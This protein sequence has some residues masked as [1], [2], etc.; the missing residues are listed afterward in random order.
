MKMW[1]AIACPRRPD[2]AFGEVNPMHYF[3][4]CWY[5]APTLLVW[6]GIWL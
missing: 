3:H 2:E 6:L 1:A 5:H 4:H